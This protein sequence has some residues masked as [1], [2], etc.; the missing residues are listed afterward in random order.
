MMFVE[1]VGVVGAGTMGAAIAEVMALNG[2]DVVLKDVEEEH[3]KQ[4]MSRIRGILDELVAYHADKADNAIQEVESDLGIQLTD[5][6]KDQVREMKS[7][8]YDKERADRVFDRI[9]PT[10]SYE[11]FEDVDIVIEAVVEDLEIKKQVFAQLEDHTERHV[12]L[13]TNTSVLSISQIASGTEDRRQ[14]VLGLHFFNPPYQMP[15]VEVVPGVE[16]HKSVVENCVTFIEEMRNHRYPMLPVVVDEGPG[17]VVNRILGRAMTEAFLIYEEGLAAPRDIDKAV[18][19]GLGWP[20]GPLELADEV[21]LDVIHH[22]NQG[23]KEMGATGHQREPQ[24]VKKLVSLGRLG[25]KSGRGFYEY[26]TEE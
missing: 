19:A 18:R 8:T 23:L 6:Q 24:I 21:G 10:T 2:H 7:P 9:Q 1:K 15:L 26:S 5:E 16:T 11:D 22:V 20:M 25:K 3:T 4:G 14:K 17:F 13:A 12:P